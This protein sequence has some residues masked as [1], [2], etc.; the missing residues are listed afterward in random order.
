MCERRYALECMQ[1]MATMLHELWQRTGN[2]L[3]THRW[4][5][6]HP[7]ASI[8]NKGRAHVT[9]HVESPRILVPRTGP[10]LADRRWPLGLGG[11]VHH[12]SCRHSASLTVSQFPIERFCSRSAC[13][14]ADGNGQAW[15]VAG[16]SKI[17]LKRAR[18]ACY[19]VRFT[20]SK[21]P[22]LVLMPSV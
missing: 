19:P 4:L 5:I 21:T 12:R 20:S 11:V 18:T 1:R 8:Q 7:K 6:D 15:S 2:A 9:S 3:A 16:P 13:L 14:M 10:R 17:P 22:R